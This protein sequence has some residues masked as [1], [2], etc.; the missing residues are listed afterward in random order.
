MKECKNLKMA[1]A[2]FRVAIEAYYVEWDLSPSSGLVLE[3]IEYYIKHVVA[4][5]A[6]R[7]GSIK[8]FRI[9]TR[10]RLVDFS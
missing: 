3:I 1:D 5:V 10:E 9:I 7:N 6:V 8:P 4:L 2:P